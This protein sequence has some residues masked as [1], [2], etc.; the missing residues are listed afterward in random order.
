MTHLISERNNEN[1]DRGYS[2]PGDSCIKS[3]PDIVM[4]CLIEMLLMGLINRNISLLLGTTI[5]MYIAENFASG[6]LYMLH[7]NCRK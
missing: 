7:V 4:I 2:L 5:N 3:C 1:N 6:V